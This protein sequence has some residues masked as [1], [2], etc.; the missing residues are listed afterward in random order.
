[1]DL[2]QPGFWQQPPIKKRTFIS[3]C[4]GFSLIELLLV[5]A[6]IAVL[7]S[8]LL[9]GTSRV[10]EKTRRTACL[11]NLRQMGIGSLLF[12]EDEPSGAL[13][14]TRDDGNDEQNWLYPDYIPNLKTF[15]CPSA[16]NTV[17]VESVRTNALTQMTYLDDLTH[18][19][20]RKGSAG[21]SYEVFGFMN[22]TGSSTTEVDGEIV[23]GVRKTLTT[24]QEYAHSFNAFQ[25][26]GVVAGP[27]QIWL[28]LDGDPNSGNYPSEEGNHGPD[29][30]NVEFCDGHVEWITRAKWGYNYEMSQ[31]ED[32]RGP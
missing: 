23:P 11:N 22:A 17:R 15:I 26:R 28:L 29:G 10:M 1:M 32:S 20:Q 2:Y 16:R 13:S 4:H 30:L 27:S 7:A 31:D 3:G 5:I 18:Y 25:L 14:W 21:S 12:A 6:I 9:M 8:L 19:A 24:V